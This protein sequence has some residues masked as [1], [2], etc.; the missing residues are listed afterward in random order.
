ML[1]IGAALQFCEQL[2]V[3][4]G[5][6][7]NWLVCHRP[8]KRPRHAEDG[9]AA[10]DSEQGRMVRSRLVSPSPSDSDC[11][12]AGTA[13]AASTSNGNTGG[14][15]ASVLPPSGFSH[16]QLNGVHGPS[17]TT[18]N[19]DE[20]AH[21]KAVSSSEHM[22]TDEPHSSAASGANGVLSQPGEEGVSDKAAGSTP[23]GP[24][25]GA[26]SNG[27]GHHLSTS[28]DESHGSGTGGVGISGGANGSEEAKEEGLPL[29]RMSWM[30]PTA[31]GHANGKADGHANGDADGTG[32]LPQWQ[33]TLVHQDGLYGIYPF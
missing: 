9:A 2:V 30:E 27:H 23:D 19:G 28:T 33:C 12:M 16:N 11:T 32:A 21:G 15:P 29:K 7:T 8:F 25:A 13:G 17:D 20:D 18:A 1:H 24:T 3:Q 31:N 26:T 22:D 5:S 10:A 4:S 6:I 14:A